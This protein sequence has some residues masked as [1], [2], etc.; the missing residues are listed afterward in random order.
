MK[1][2]IAFIPGLTMLLIG[3]KT[4]KKERNGRQGYFII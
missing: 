1:V 2:K 4:L 3:L